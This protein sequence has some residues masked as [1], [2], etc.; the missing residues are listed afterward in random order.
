MHDPRIGR[1]FAVDSLAKKYPEE[2]AKRMRKR[3]MEASRPE[4]SV[5]YEF[6]DIGA[7]GGIGYGG[8]AG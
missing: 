7:A 1:F 4:N 8:K 3:M 6:Y 5:V 2:K